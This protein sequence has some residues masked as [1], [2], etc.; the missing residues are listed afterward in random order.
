MTRRDDTLDDAAVGGPPGRSAHDETR[1]DFCDPVVVQARARVGTLVGNKWHL[2]AL[3]GAGGMAAVYAATHRNGTRAALKILHV[4]LSTDRTVRSRFQREGYA[5]NSVGHPGAVRVLDDDILDDGSPF[6]VSELL[7]GETL[8]DRRER[9]GGRLSVAEVLTYAD[10]LLDV[11][12]AAH[13]NGVVHRDLKPDN[14]FLTR[15]GQLKVLDFGIARIRDLAVDSHLT[16]N[17]ALLGTPRFM[18]PEQARGLAEE[19]DPQSDL[20]ACGATMF[21]LLSG[22]PVFDAPTPHQVLML[23]ATIPAPAFETVWPE[24]P[25]SVAC[26]IDRALAF[27]KKDRWPDARAMQQAVRAAYCDRRGAPISPARAPAHGVDMVDPE[28]I[29]RTRRASRRLT[30][31][32]PAVAESPP[33]HS[34]AKR[35]AARCDMASVRMAAPRGAA[36]NAVAA[37]RPRVPEG[38]PALHATMSDGISDQTLTPTNPRRDDRSTDRPV[39]ATVP[40]VPPVSQRVQ[41]ALPAFV[42]GAGIAAAIAIAVRPGR[43]PAARIDLSPLATPAPAPAGLRPTEPPENAF[44]ETAVTTAAATSEPAPR[45]R[46]TGGSLSTE[47]S[48]PHVGGSRGSAQA[49]AHSLAT[50]VP[51]GMSAMSANLAPAAADAH[52]SPAAA[53]GEPASASHALGSAGSVATSIAGASAAPERKVAR[54]NCMQ[55]DEPGADG[56]GASRVVC[57]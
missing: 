16:K 33:A 27:Q 52:R 18:P 12:V 34:V 30:T 11:L 32:R 53:P 10:A 6:L 40:S 4:A 37:R 9:L 5:A 31:G 25:P 42:L 29:R 56:G 20:W 23:A 28:A 1:T 3:L 41:I 47:P 46:A 57:L 22:R 43:A 44:A 49:V 26:L 13:A 48:A 19:V 51:A 15:S 14:L 55:L 24:A 7:D 38:L 39:V 8:E 21:D 50:T 54:R 35:D 2:D 17:G 36:P 45:E